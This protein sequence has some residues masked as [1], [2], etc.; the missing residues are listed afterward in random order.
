MNFIGISRGVR[1]KRHH[2]VCQNYQSFSTSLFLTRER[3][4]ETLA[5]VGV[6]RRSDPMFIGNKWRHM[7]EGIELSM[8]MMQ[9]DPYLRSLIFE[10]KQVREPLLL[11]QGQT[12]VLP[13]RYQTFDVR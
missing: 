2:R 12:P 10:R 6:V 11:F 13:H 9:R 8:G 3:A 7:V 4:H 5:S 1:D